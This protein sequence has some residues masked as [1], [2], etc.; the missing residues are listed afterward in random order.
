MPHP[1]GQVLNHNLGSVTL[2]YP[3]LISRL[4]VISHDKT[5]HRVVGPVSRITLCLSYPC[6]FTTHPSDPGRG[7]DPPPPRGPGGPPS[8]FLVLMVGAPESLAAAPRGAR[9][10]HFLALMVGAPKFT[11]STSQGGC[12]RRFLALMVGAPGF[13]GNTRQGGPSSTFSRDDGGQSRIFISTRQ[14]ARHRCFLALMVGA[15][16]FFGS[17]SQGG[18]HRHFLPLM[19]S[20]P[21]SQSAAT[22]GLTINVF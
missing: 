4:R 10:Q 22:K 19:V 12:H 7:P 6:W 1:P 17:T 3:C 9:H 18:H 20:D 11:D 8:T 5:K 2:N 14:G 21:E 13:S 15:P 16:R